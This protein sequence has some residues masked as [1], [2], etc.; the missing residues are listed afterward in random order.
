MIRR[1]AAWLAV[2]AVSGCAGSSD[3]APS[4][5]AAPVPA[6]RPS[7]SAGVPAMSSAAAKPPASPTSTPVALDER[8]WAL[9]WTERGELVVARDGALKDAD[10]DLLDY[11]APE[12]AAKHACALVETL[13]ATPLHHLAAFECSSTVEGLARRGRY[14][15][16]HPAGAVRWLGVPLP[17]ASGPPPCSAPEAIGTSE[18]STTVPLAPDR[19]GFVTRGTSCEGPRESVTAG[20]APTGFGAP[21]PGDSVGPRSRPPPTG[22]RL[23][24]VLSGPLGVVSAL[25][26]GGVAPYGRREVLVYPLLTR[27]VDGFDG[28]PAGATAVP[29]EV[30][31]APAGIACA[32]KARRGPD[33][34]GA[35]TQPGACRGAAA[36]LAE[37]VVFRGAHALSEALLA[38]GRAVEAHWADPWSEAPLERLFELVGTGAR[39]P[40]GTPK[41]EDERRTAPAE[42]LRSLVELRTP[43][44]A[45]FVHRVAT[46]ARFARAR[47]DPLVAALLTAAPK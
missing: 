31:L 17:L 38:A 39:V 12:A 24:G 16:A 46:E 47:S 3:P 32:V 21:M 44:A 4:A 5:A 14:P 42:V 27:K 8:L 22:L 1:R 28:L 23:L 2:L 26:V 25:V 30:A 37:G 11:E 7:P 19:L 10:D 45:A 34:L 40:C 6:L 13:G 18:A 9:G 20:W 29:S 33:A 43:R 15:I 41:C 35:A 36:A